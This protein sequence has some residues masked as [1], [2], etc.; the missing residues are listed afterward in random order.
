MLNERRKIGT[1]VVYKYQPILEILLLKFHN[2]TERYAVAMNLMQY[3]HGLKDFGCTLQTS[4][5][6]KLWWF[7]HPSRDVKSPVFQC[8][9]IS[10]GCQKK[11]DC[12]IGGG[13]T[14]TYCYG[15]S[16][17]E[18]KNPLFGLKAKEVVAQYEKRGSYK[19]GVN[20]SCKY[21]YV[22]HTVCRVGLFRPQ[23][24]WQGGNIVHKFR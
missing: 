3:F 15:S 1:P 17:Y 11:S 21:K 6:T 16:C 24:I 9:L 19:K 10:E 20:R 7:E 14:V 5:D 4:G 12:K 2:D 18:H 22:F 8:K 23:I 13:G